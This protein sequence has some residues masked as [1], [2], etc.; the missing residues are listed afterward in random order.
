MNEYFTDLVNFVYFDHF[1]QSPSLNTTR[2]ISWGPF[3]AQ[4]K[5]KKQKRTKQKQTHRKAGIILGS[6][7]SSFRGL[8]RPGDWIPSS[9]ELGACSLAR[10]LPT[11]RRFNRPEQ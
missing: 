6:I 9:P 10:P 7:W 5:T 11:E 2:K 1:S 4:P 8:Y 3:R